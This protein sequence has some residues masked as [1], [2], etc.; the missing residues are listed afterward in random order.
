MKSQKAEKLLKL[1]KGEELKQYIFVVL[2]SCPD[3]TIKVIQASH[4]EAWGKDIVLKLI[5]KNDPPF[6]DTEVS[7]IV[8]RLRKD[9]TR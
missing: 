3:G 7:K 2:Q 6:D 9:L 4:A 8:E 1:A 5:S